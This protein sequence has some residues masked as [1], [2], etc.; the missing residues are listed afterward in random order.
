MDEVDLAIQQALQQQEA[1]KAEIAA[2]QASSTS[3]TAAQLGISPEEEAR[4]QQVYGGAGQAQKQFMFDVASTPLNLAAGLADVAALPAVGVARLAGVDKETLPAFG[5]TKLL[6]LGKQKLAESLGVAPETT[7]QEVLG[8]IAPSPVSK[9]SPL[10]QAVSGLSAYGGMKAGEAFFPESPYAGIVG[11]LAPGSA[12]PLVKAG[13]AKFAPGLA[14]GLIK[15][16]KAF[17]RAQFGL[18]QPDYTAK[19]N[20]ILEVTE[21]EFVTQLD[22]SAD[23]LIEQKVL[24]RTSNPD[25]LYPAIQTAK[26]NLEQEI[27]TSLKKA[28]KKVGVIEPP[29]FE[30]AMQYVQEGKVPAN[31]VDNYLKEIVD[32]QEGVAREGKGSLVY[33]NN[34]RKAI[35][36][37]WS[38]K[39]NAD[40]GFWRAFYRDIKSHIEK[41]APEIEGLH[42]RKQDLVVIEPVVEK[43]K[44]AGQSI[45][46][47]FDANKWFYTTGTLGLPGAY[48]A[49][50]PAGIPVAL[51]LAAAGSKPGR[52]TIGRA[53]QAAGERAQTPATYDLARA[54]QSAGAAVDVPAEEV[55]EADQIQQ[56]LAQQEQIKAAIAAL[57]S[58]T[59]TP[60]PTATPTVTATPT[61]TPTVEP[62]ET[63]PPT[64]TITAKGVSYEIPVGDKY[65]EPELVKAVVAVESNNNPKAKSKVG[66]TGF[67]QLMPATAKEL[68]VDIN[69]PQENIEGGS[70]YL[71]TLI[72]R[73]DSVELALAAYN[74][75][76]GNIANALRKLKGEGREPTWENIKRFSPR[77]PK[78]TRLYVG[79]VLS[80]LGA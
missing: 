50:G 4:L 80:K 7:A 66:A 52:M 61:E 56:A 31:E 75:G 55:S 60:K 15:K 72:D 63:V 26:K 24:P 23:N 42:K 46:E 37:N 8:F 39:V 28:Q 67:M 36:E 3:S 9:L 35:G 43:A 68:K 18:R 71:Q 22:K 79:K 33:L 21:D 12:G 78:E 54:L 58:E 20:T 74:W 17:Q 57:Q 16:G 30:R 51:G 76:Q 59:A 77:L 32:F 62:T 69:D 65:P 34:Q 38:N 64:P 11:A 25:K 41:Y 5:T 47:R 73:F 14:P 19:K 6:Q 48:M 40:A 27:Q 53:L 70:R 45:R 2:L 44:K 13:A 1:I 29:P 10:K 49:L